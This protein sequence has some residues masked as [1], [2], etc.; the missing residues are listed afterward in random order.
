MSGVWAPKL[1]GES[2]NPDVDANR[3]PQRSR[4][5]ANIPFLV[6]RG[7]VRRCGWKCFIL[8]FREFPR[9]PFLVFPVTDSWSDLGFETGPSSHSRRTAPSQFN[10]APAGTPLSQFGG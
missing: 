10:A 6:K 8:E 4:A 3:R 1:E 2:R 7:D 9:L 5:V